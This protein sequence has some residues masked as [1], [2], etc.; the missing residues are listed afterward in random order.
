MIVNAPGRGRVKSYR[1]C[2]RSEA[3]HRAAKEEWIA[4][5]FALWRFGGLAPCEACAASVEGSSHSLL[6]MTASNTIPHS[7]DGI[8]PSL[9]IRPPKMRAQGMPDAQC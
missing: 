8:R 1:H 5:T 2:E 6:A 4:S 7:R 3:I 9:E